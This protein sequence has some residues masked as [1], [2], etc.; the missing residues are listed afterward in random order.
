M[1]NSFLSPSYIF[2]K[3]SAYP[4]N[5][6][7]TS[8]SPN[9]LSEFNKSLETPNEKIHKYEAFVSKLLD[10][11]KKLLDLVDFQKNEIR[12]LHKNLN[13][14]EFLRNSP[15]KFNENPIENHDK[16]AKELDF[17][18]NYQ[19]LYEEI[20]EKYQI[21]LRENENLEKKNKG[22]MQ[23]INEITLE[24]RK[25]YDL[26]REMKENNQEKYKNDENK[27]KYEKIMDLI[28]EMGEKEK[29]QED[30]LFKILDLE[31]KINQL[32]MENDKLHK[33]IQD[34]RS[35]KNFNY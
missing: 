13:N 9:E 15:G 19:E 14:F 11:N 25:L 33:F 24:N 21:L 6:Q 30:Y 8:Q 10:E 16:N 4:V 32:L 35:S 3:N 2:Y 7:I 34:L 1:K 29:S 18:Q 12:N 20:Q 31:N 28:T 23:K 5:F 27:I 22:Y 17:S 26:M